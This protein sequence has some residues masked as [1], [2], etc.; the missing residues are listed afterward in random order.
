MH[1]NKT[2]VVTSINPAGK[3]D[4]QRLCF[5]RW[6]SLG[7][8]VITCNTRLESDMLVRNGFPE[9]RIRPI[10]M[11]H[12]G[13]IIF[14]KPVPLIKPLLEALYHEQKYDCIVLTNSDIYPSI[15]TGSIVSY[16]AMHSPALAMTREEIHDLFAH[17]YDS[18]SP[19][20]GG[21]DVFFLQREAL[22]RVNEMLNAFASSSRMAFGMPGWDYLMAAVILSPAVGGRIFDSHLL[23]HQSHRPTYGN[24]DEFSHYV[25]DLRQLGAVTD[26]TPSGAAAEF[27][28]VIERECRNQH[29]DSRMAKLLYY[30][31]PVRRS[32]S[33]QRTMEFE[34]CWQQMLLLAPGMANC[35]RKWTI[36]SLYERL[37]NDPDASLETALPL[38]CNSK[39][40]WFQFN[41]A[42]FAIVLSLKARSVTKSRTFTDN[43]PKG[44]Q[45]GAALRNILN[46]HDENDPLRRFWIARLF[47]S[48]LVNHG[49]FNRRLFNYLVLATENDSEL[50]LTQEILSMIRRKQP[51]AA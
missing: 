12:S 16:W 38:V 32:V 17:D 27:A 9:N 18:S 37:A 50:Q 30:Q 47:G 31:K 21:L 39:S 8:D 22:A 6:Q 26:I 36:C 19:Y 28:S 15:R 44:N 35:Y 3:L 41:Q 40:A 25:Q 5:D 13:K 45:H 49:I 46:R 33:R 1:V 48:E 43:Y 11:E 24:M 51:N 2:L 14:G 20:R 7:M 34:R 29:K 4:H 42:L 23:L 10:N